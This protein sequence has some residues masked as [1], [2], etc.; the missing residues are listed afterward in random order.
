MRVLTVSAGVD[1]N[2][3]MVTGCGHCRA[4]LRFGV[5]DEAEETHL[6]SCHP[7]FSAATTGLVEYLQQR[8]I[9]DEDLS[10]QA[11]ALC[12]QRWKLA[13]DP[14]PNTWELVTP[15]ALPFVP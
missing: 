1:N 9:E 10:R 12:W 6:G 11:E 7:D 5:A 8:C 4:M 3:L 2:L 15:L 14:D 13:S